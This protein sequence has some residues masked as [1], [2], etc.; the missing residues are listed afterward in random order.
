MQARELVLGR[1][2]LHGDGRRI[3]REIAN[4][5]PIDHLDGAIASKKP[6]RHEPPNETLQTDVGTGHTPDVTCFYELDVI[7]ANN[8][9]S[10]DVRR[11]LFAAI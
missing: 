9:L 3:G 2:Q 7:N 6:L 8:A 4:I 11:G 1:F 5:G 10:V